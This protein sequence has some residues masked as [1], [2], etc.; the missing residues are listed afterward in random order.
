MD[1]KSGVN[2]VFKS[3]VIMV[4]VNGYD[5]TWLNAFFCLRPISSAINVDPKSPDV[6][7]EK[8]TNGLNKNFL[9]VFSVLK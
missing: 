6:L 4:K 5:K 8:K 1:L 2:G 9:K 7:D 3:S